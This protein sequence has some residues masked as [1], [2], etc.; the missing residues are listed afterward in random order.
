ME[1]DNIWMKGAAAAAAIG[2][3]IG[4]A[5]VVRDAK[6]EGEAKAKEEWGRQFSDLVKNQQVV[7]RFSPS[8]ARKWF[9]QIFKEGEGVLY[10]ARFTPETARM[11]QIR[12]AEPLDPKHYLL[13][14]AQNKKTK[15][16]EGIQLVNFGELPSEFE[17]L[18]EKSGGIATFE[19]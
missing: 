12:G 7:E 8:W 18:L 16:L 15:K 9:E 10:I 19:G 14:A 2:A 13:L 1:K 5:K 6:K 4:M 3:A 11:F 17:K